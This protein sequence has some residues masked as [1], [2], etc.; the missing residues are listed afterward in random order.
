MNYYAYSAMKSNKISSTNS[1]EHE[2]LYRH[3]IL[4]RLHKI[5]TPSTRR[6]LT[7]LDLTLSPWRHFATSSDRLLR[8]VVGSARQL[9]RWWAF[10]RGANCTVASHSCMVL[11]GGQ[12]TQ[13]YPVVCRLLLSTPNKL[14]TYWQ[15]LMFVTPKCI[16]AL[17]EP[18]T[19]PLTNLDRLDIY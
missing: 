16:F 2:L 5:D 9:A 17:L 18:F 1:N 10:L 14:L 11:P 12:S 8:V 15:W 6:Y 3:K 4:L 13:R 7:F 19:S